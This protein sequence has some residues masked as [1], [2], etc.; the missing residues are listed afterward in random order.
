[1]KAAEG[2]ARQWLGAQGRRCSRREHKGRLTGCWPVPGLM[3][4]GGVVLRGGD[5]WAGTWWA[6]PGAP[7]RAQRR[8]RA[9]FLEEL[10]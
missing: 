5:L 1:M 7:A 6:G 4:T 2:M 9:V 8:L 10:Q 3:M